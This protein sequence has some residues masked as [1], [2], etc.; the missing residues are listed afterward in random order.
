LKVNTIGRDIV[1]V[2]SGRCQETIPDF[3]DVV[4]IMKIMI[5]AALDVEFPMF[6][7]NLLDVVRII[8]LAELV[9]FALDLL[10]LIKY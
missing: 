9:E 7:S 2:D 4:R 6:A 10:E 1:I 5:L 8:I 3:A